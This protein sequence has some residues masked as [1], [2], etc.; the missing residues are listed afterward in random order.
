VSVPASIASRTQTRLADTTL[1][2]LA[3]I[4]GVAGTSTVR[5]IDA[6]TADGIDL[7]L[8]AISPGPGT[9]ASLTWAAGTRA[10]AERVFATGDEVLVSE[11]LAWR[12]G[13]TRGSLLSLRGDHGIENLPV[14][15]IFRDY[16]AERGWALI[17]RTGFERR[18][19]DRAVGG[20]ALWAVASV[21][22]DALLERARAAAAECEQELTVESSR[23]LREASLE[24]FDRTFSITDVLRFLCVIV[25]VLGIW[26]ALSA[27]QLERGRETGLLRAV[28]ATPGQVVRTLVIQNALLGLCAGLLALPTGALLAWL[29]VA[30]VNRRSFGWTLLD[31]GIPV[32]VAAE[33]IGLAIGAALIAGI[34]PA[35]RLGRTSITAALRD[36]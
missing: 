27:L 11:P 13:L 32:G 2:R 12:L 14:A 36:E 15:G 5:R 7:E 6:T 29:L 3:R 1:Q 33:A 26:S 31:F 4:D 10:D 8:A 9:I 28:G 35:V 22:A 25:A 20:I 19:V 16:A 34:W 18:F 23:G 21:G 24:I 17:S 30:V